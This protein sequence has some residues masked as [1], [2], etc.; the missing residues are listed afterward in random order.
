[1]LHTPVA[2]NVERPPAPPTSITHAVYPVASE[3]K[4]GLLLGLLAEPGVR[5]VLAFTRTKHRANRLADFLARHDVTVDRIHGNRSQAQ[6]TQACR[7]SST[8]RSASRRHRP[9]A[10]GRHHRAIHL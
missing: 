1:M 7:V 10:R 4:S 5:S 3:L 9:R 2:I 8:A 6:R